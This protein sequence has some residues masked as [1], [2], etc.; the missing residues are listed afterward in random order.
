MRS[1]D[2]EFIPKIPFLRQRIMRVMTGTVAESKNAINLLQMSLEHHHPLIAGLLA[3]M[4]LEALFDSDNRQQFHDK[5][6]QCLGASATAFPDWNSSNSLPCPPYT[7]DEIAID[8][9]TLRSKIAHGVDLRDAARDRRFPVDLLRKV[10]LIPDLPP[11]P[12]ALLLSEA[13]ICVLCQVL[14]KAL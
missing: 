7:V 12:Y 10:T 5:L 1:F 4:G 3:V 6:C 2:S 14:Q 13:A 8:L 11:R 9:Y